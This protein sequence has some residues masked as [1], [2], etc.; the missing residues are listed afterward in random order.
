MDNKKEEPAYTI[1]DEEKEDGRIKTVGAHKSP[2]MLYTVIS[3][4]L[5]FVLYFGVKQAG[6]FINREYRVTVT[7]ADFSS[8]N[9]V[10]T[11]ILT[12]ADTNT[13]RIA[14]T[15]LKTGMSLIILYSDETDEE[16]FAAD[17]IN[18][19]YGNTVEDY[20]YK[21]VFNEFV[22]GTV[23]VYIDDPEIYCV[24]YEYEDKVYAEYNTDEIKAE[25]M[26]MIRSGEK[27][28]F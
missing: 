7:G 12:D 27:M 14:F 21:N 16:K 28:Y 13:E 15:K 2:A 26:K 3:V 8:V 23:Y 17:S 25:V 10:Y 6:D 4:V 24:V 22:F 18:F 19:E 5:F 1:S 20:R 11:D 9:E